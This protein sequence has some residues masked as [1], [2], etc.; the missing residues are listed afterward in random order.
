M[1]LDSR[2]SRKS[3]LAYICI[4]LARDSLTCF[5]CSSRIVDI[6][7]FSSCLQCP[8]IQLVQIVC[9]I[10]YQQILIWQQD[11]FINLLLC[12]FGIDSVLLTVFYSQSVL[13]VTVII[14]SLQVKHA[15]FGLW[16]YC[17]FLSLFIH[18]KVDYI[19]YLHS[20][21]PYFMLLS[22]WFPLGSPAHQSP[23]PMLLGG[24]L[25]KRNLSIILLCRY[26][27]CV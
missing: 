12:L 26:V 9:Q 3:T 16:I 4:Y 5:I 6:Y 17:S 20:T 10:N 19:N 25:F 15:C 23:K 2:I 14:I 24:R 1:D 7:S 22:G 8:M 18:V 27:I 11:I 21:Y 13:H